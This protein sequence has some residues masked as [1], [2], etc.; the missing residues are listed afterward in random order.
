MEVCQVN[1][2]VVEPVIQIEIMRIV[3]LLTRLLL[4][5]IPTLN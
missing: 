4:K 1:A 5:R 2:P 3:D